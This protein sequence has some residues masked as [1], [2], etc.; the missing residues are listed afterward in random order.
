MPENRKLIHLQCFMHWL[1]AIWFLLLWDIEKWF[2][3]LGM[4]SQRKLIYSCDG[5]CSMSVPTIMSAIERFR[6]LLYDCTST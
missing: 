3:Q 2:K 6:G 4:V 5:I 1:D